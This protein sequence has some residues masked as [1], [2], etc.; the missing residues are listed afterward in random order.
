MEEIVNKLKMSLTEK[1]PSLLLGAGFSFGAQ[2][3]K[4]E[5]LPVGAGLLEKLYDELYVNNPP[6]TVIFEED[7]D[8]AISYKEM[9]NYMKVIIDEFIRYVI[10]NGMEKSIQLLLLHDFGQLQDG[11]ED[12]YKIENLDI[13]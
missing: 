2:N 13:F 6:S 12:E 9:D 5:D 10:S 8:A 1:S 3:G 4:N 7:N 11:C